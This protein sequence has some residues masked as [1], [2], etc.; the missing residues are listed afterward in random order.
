MIAGLGILL[1][2]LVQP[3]G[4]FDNCWC[5][6]MTFDRPAQAVAFMTGN[7]VSQWGVFRYWVGGLTMAFA[8]AS[9]FGLSIYLGA[10]RRG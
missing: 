5:S 6:T 7:F 2:S 3:L 9:L 8:I 1:I 10:P 4:I